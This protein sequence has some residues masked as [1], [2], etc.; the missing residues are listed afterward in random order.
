MAGC[1]GIGPRSRQ[2]GFC[3]TGAAGG[4]PAGGPPPTGWCLVAAPRTSATLRLR[5]GRA[6]LL[7]RFVRLLHRRLGLRNF[8]PVH[9]R[10]TRELL[11]RLPFAG[12]LHVVSP[13]QGWISATEE[14]AVTGTGVVVQ[15]AIPV[16]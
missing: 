13:G 4:S 12:R 3:S 1:W 15:I 9:V 8:L 5:R 16:V 7:S 6:R 14:G 11:D 2:S 10:R